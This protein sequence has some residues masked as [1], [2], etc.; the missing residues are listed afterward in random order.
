MNAPA[1]T[2]DAE[3]ARLAA[4]AHLQPAHFVEFQ[5][6]AK[7]LIHGPQFQLLIVD[8]R[9]ER[10]RAKV[11]ESLAL[12]QQQAGLRGAELVLDDSVGDVQALESRLVALATEHEVIHVMGASHWMDAGRWESFNLLRERL[13][14]LV[15]VRLVL[16]LNAEAIGLV[17]R[18]APDIWAWRSGI[19][20]FELSV[21]SI[22]INGVSAGFQAGAGRPIIS[23]T[24]YG[25]KEKFQRLGQ[26]RDFLAA[27]PSPSDELKVVLLNEMGDLLFFLGYLDDSLVIRRDELLPLFGKMGRTRE[28]AITSGKIAEILQLK[29]DF[30]LALQILKNDVLPVFEALGDAALQ[31]MALSKIADIAYMQGDFDAALKIRRQEVLP[32]YQKLGQERSVA[33]TLGQVADVLQAKGDLGE[34]LRIRQ[35]EVLPVYERVGDIRSR[36]VVMGK[37]ADV[38]WE[39][40]RFDE[41]L[42]IRREEQLPIYE[43]LGDMRE[44][45]VGRTRLAVC[46]MQR[47]Y[48]SDHAEIENLLRLAHAAAQRL[49]LPEE[50]QIAELYERF[51]GANINSD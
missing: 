9:D 12:V 10:L 7:S 51:L 20:T 27:T 41:A 38:L 11:L 31:A 44:L 48:N 13:S 17:A 50:H 29:L 36:A 40:G 2:F 16:W 23:L 45:L 22:F 28:C 42:I 43:K 32:I 21:S 49:G 33:V 3:Q 15:R 6:L 25:M 37:I 14:L 18:Y 5:R 30:Q 34:A 46:L 8:C 47:G 35:Q 1:P 19:Y 24:S 39:E 4:A 26:L